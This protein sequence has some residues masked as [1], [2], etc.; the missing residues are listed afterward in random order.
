MPLGMRTNDELVLSK[1]DDADDATSV[2]GRW[3]CPVLGPPGRWKI[4]LHLATD[5]SSLLSHL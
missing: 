4:L 5:R 2:L 3:A 1:A